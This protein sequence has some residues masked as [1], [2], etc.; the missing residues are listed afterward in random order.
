LLLL[1]NDDGFD[2][3][4]IAALRAELVS[5]ADVVT[6]APKYNQSAASHALT[7]HSVLRLERIE[8][9][10]FAVDGTPADCIYVALHSKE[11]VLPRRPDLVVSGM[12]HGPNLGADVVYS[13]TVAAAREG[14][15]RGIPAIA[16]SAD[17][18]AAPAEAARLGS[19]I[20]HATWDLWSSAARLSD[21]VLLNVNIPPGKLWST[22]PTRL[23]VRLYDDE[24][25]FRSDPRGHEYLW[26]GGSKAHHDLTEGTD[27]AAYEAGVASIT[28]L[29]INLFAGAEAFA[30][31]HD[32]VR[33]MG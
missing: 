25:V 6:C 29:A 30:V 21:G 22:M 23:G 9:G 20:V 13:G 28:P 16:V 32:V 15:I 27:T 17:S 2:S 3:P 11:R 10:V 33:H 14:A 26:I 31:A 4:G 8:P 18:R 1:S 12:N 5:F 19:R 24:V 7:L